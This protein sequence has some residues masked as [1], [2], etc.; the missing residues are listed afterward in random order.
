MKNQKT[1]HELVE[2]VLMKMRELKYSEKTLKS[3]EKV[4]NSFK[5]F[6]EGKN[7]RFYTTDTGME[8]LEQKCKFISNYPV[9]YTM[10][11]KVRAINR[12]DEYYK[13]EIISTKRP[14]RKIYI[15]PD[16]YKKQVNS[17][18]VCR[19]A[20]GLSKVRIQAINSYLER[21]T[22][23]LYDIG[24]KK[25]EEL[26][27][28]HVNGFTQFSTQYT[29]STVRNTFTCLRGFL[30]FIYEKGY[31]DKNLSFVI[32]SIRLA[33]ECTIPSA[34]SR[35][36]VERILSCINRSNIKEIRDYA[37][38]LLAARLGLRASDITNLTFS[39]LN[40]E[41]NLI[42]IVQEK[43]KK[44]LQLPLLN[45]V[46]DAIIDYLRLRPKV[47]SEYVFL[48]IENPPEKMH[49]H[50]LYEITNKYI[51]R[52]KV[53]VPPGKKHGPHALRHSLSSM[54]LE[55]NV[56]LPVISEILSHAS[57]ETTKVYL[58]IDVSHLR[59]CALEVPDIAVEV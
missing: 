23:Y 53:Y 44:L 10:E 39:S 34:Y 52:A 29:A 2:I 28:S 58:K 55:K 30:S 32:P 35:D 46:G 45:E 47:L 42:E 41:K 7:I 4:W 8:F 37:M 40:W 11:E 9:K 25:I 57:T 36:E 26:Q 49:G 20:G 18:I 33:R 48:R 13:Y 12:I 5:A 3:Y 59:E 31:T 6:A 15:F 43:T 54:M 22:N 21:F 56:P 27:A 19:K 51:K 50:S 17:Y 38:L 1:I 14:Q 24:L 16:T